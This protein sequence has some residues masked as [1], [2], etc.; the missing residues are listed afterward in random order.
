[1]LT[2]TLDQ[3]YRG[4]IF[5]HI[6]GGF[7]RYSTDNKWLVP[8]FE[9]MLY[10]NALLSLTYSEA[11]NCTGDEL[12]REIACLSIDYVLREMTDEEG[13]FFC[14]QD[15][16]SQGEEG[17]FYTFRQEEILKL[18]GE[19]TGS[20]FCRRYGIDEKGN[21]EG[22]S[23][24][25]LLG[26]DDYRQARD[27]MDDALSLLLSYRKGR[28]ELHRDDK[29]LASWNALIIASL[30]RS[31][32]LLERKDYLETAIKS[33]KSFEIHFARD[34]GSLSLRWRDGEAAFEG[35]LDDYAFY[36]WALLELYAV[37]YEAGY[38]T[39]ACEITDIMLENF[40]DE[41]GGFYLYSEKSQKLISRPK[42]NY[43]GAIPSGNS[44]AAL[45]LVRL[46]KLTGEGKWKDAFETQL[47]YLLS[48][49]GEY[50]A[51]HIF[52]LISAMEYTFPSWELVC[53]PTEDWDHIDLSSLLK[54][55]GENIY[56]VVKTP[57]NQE[58]LGAVAPF[59]IDYPLPIK[60]DENIYYFCRD[61]ACMAPC[62]IE[63]LKEYLLSAR[64]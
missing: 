16:D 40:F 37:T 17:S 31:S 60:G 14:A 25:N 21:F 41:K 20:E 6:G 51:G 30:S 19:K 45:V 5:D 34:D 22:K 49:M 46:W 56:T 33:Q 64:T 29:E 24:A 7:S 36:A 59:T 9:K 50:P 12:Y 11:F 62:N 63:K 23:I 2:K 13:G 42:E 4:G 8:H 53:T 39:R 48:A 47:G 58:E 15:A 10:D 1:M 18:L 55:L 44:V 61:G 28:M 38:L 27:G 32:F 35:H 3:M 43:D 26:N 52:A 57:S 54:T